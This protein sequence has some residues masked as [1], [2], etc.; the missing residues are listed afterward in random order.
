MSKEF[1]ENYFKPCVKDFVSTVLLI[2]DQLEYQESLPIEKSLDS[3]IPGKSYSSNSENSTSSTGRNDIKR[4]VY[5]TD[6][7][8]S[9]SKEELL[10]TP[11]NPTKL[12]AQNKDDCIDILLK[13]AAKSDVIILDWDMNISFSEGEG[14]SSNELSQKLITR[15]NA[16]NK[17]R[18]VM[19]YTADKEDTVKQNLPKASNIEIKIY[20]KS[21]TTGTV[22]KEYDE[23]AAQINIDF[24]AEKKGLL[25]A[26]LLTS[27]TAIRKST[28]SML[29]ALNKDF[30]IALLYHRILLTTPDKINDFCKDIISDEILTHIASEYIMPC[31]DKDVFKAYLFE[32]KV[33]LCFKTNDKEQRK[34]LKKDELD[35][36]LENGYK[37]YF[38]DDTSDLIAK[39]KY[40]NYIVQDN[41]TVK[42]KAFSYYSLML[43]HDIQP[44]LQLGCIVR[45]E[46]KF[47]LCIQPLCDTER[48][49]K[50]GDLMNKDIPQ[51]LF[52]GLKENS[53]VDFFIKKDNKY[54]GLQVEYSDIAT[55]PVYGNDCGIVELNE[56]KYQLS[57]GGFLEFIDCLKPMFAQ[58]IANAF[59]ANISRVGIDQFEWLRLKGRC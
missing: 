6:L 42:L 1:T 7:I 41:D 14:F 20:G 26:V 52:L 38:T 59:A 15:L 30:D 18:L 8:K 35:S 13:L 55:F 17:Y 19:I 31:M 24:L 25:G 11:V 36:L 50:K 57:N 2:D 4:K 45:I 27:L 21:K 29:N 23:L 39:G 22:V 58:K 10:V 12:G 48:I 33:K 43:G 44:K 53:K 16:D 47:Y 54:I 51:F 40:L 32:K 56:N 46:E 49:P 3:P 5:V 37:S 28:Y 9:F 34:E